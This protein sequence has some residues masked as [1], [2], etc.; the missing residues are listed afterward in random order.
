[1]SKPPY[2]T[3]PKVYSQRNSS[4]IYKNFNYESTGNSQFHTQSDFFKA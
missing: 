3:V 4:L 2:Q 1:M